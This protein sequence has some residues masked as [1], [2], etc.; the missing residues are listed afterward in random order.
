MRSS[1]V[2]V[3]PSLQKNQQIRNYDNTSSNSTKPLIEC[4]VCDFS[5]ECINEFIEHI[6][7][8]HG[9]KYC[10]ILS[11]CEMCNYAPKNLADLQ[12]HI[13]SYHKCIACDYCNLSVSSED[14]MR[15]H[16][17]KAHPTI[18]RFNTVASQVDRM[19]EELISNR[20]RHLNHFRK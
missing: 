6:V 19:S 14:Y 10:I 13:D 2:K 11:N 4:K 9:D 3:K 18:I 20:T 1:H 5:S 7:S 16:V 8:R 12:S 17:Y 15:N